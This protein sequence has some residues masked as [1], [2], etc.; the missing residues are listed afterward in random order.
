MPGRLEVSRTFD[1]APKA[2]GNTAK[3]LDGVNSGLS[4]LAVL[5]GALGAGSNVLLTSNLPGMEEEVDTF[6]DPGRLEVSRTFDPAPKAPGN[7]AKLLDGVNSGL[8]F[9]G[10][11]ASPPPPPSSSCPLATEAQA[12][13]NTVQQFGRVA[14]GLGRWAGAGAKV[15]AGMN[16]GAGVNPKLVC[17]RRR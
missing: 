4:N 11:G 5:P 13:V 7:T 12:T 14:R 2:P 8:S 1:P 16:S 10:Q 9:G 15:D 6:A 3:L 17:H